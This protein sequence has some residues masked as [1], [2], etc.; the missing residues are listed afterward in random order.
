MAVA[1]AAPSTPARASRAKPLGD[2][3]RAVT[4]RT[5]EGGADIQD[6]ALKS[7]EAMFSL[8]LTPEQR[9]ALT[10]AYKAAANVVRIAADVNGMAT[11]LLADKSAEAYRAI[12]DF[13]AHKR[14]RKVAK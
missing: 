9:A 12:D 5:K 11:F 6:E 10:P 1:K 8:N 14:E 4:R 2:L 13:D 7:M 3:A